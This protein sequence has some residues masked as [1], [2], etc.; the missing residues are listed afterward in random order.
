MNT[1]AREGSRD[2]I[3]VL[4]M[5]Y[6]SPTDL[7][8]LEQYLKG[9]VHSRE[10]S[11]S[12]IR[13]FE[14]RYTAIGGRSPMNDILKKQRAALERA[15]NEQGFMSKVY[16]GTKHWRPSVSEALD[17][18]RNDGFT[19]VIALPLS[20]YNS[21]WVMSSYEQALSE[22]IKETAFTGKVSWVRGWNK[23]R[24]FL[25]FWKQSITEAYGGSRHP[26]LFSAH[27]LPA[28]MLQ[29]KDRYPEILRETSSEI[30][31][32]VNPTYW[33]F[34]YQSAGDASDAWLKPD[35]KTKLTEFKEKGYGS[36]VVAC[37][38]FVFD[39][40]EVLYDLDVVARAHAEKTGIKMIRAR[41]PNDDP[42]F[43]KALASE[44][45]AACNLVPT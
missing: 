2:E 19:T 36:V 21:Y 37:I 8:E 11:E 38:G 32:L 18:M 7:S 34:T 12:F 17:S 4:M 22:A 14:S 25:E 3:A 27:S 24:F 23:N 33:E 35:I 15:L 45:E 20:P 30:A 43:I 42:L 31:R 26:V 1:A 39:H 28:R 10:V 6:G 44:V 9:I 41:Q 16:I 40:L 5:G 13:D 29:Y